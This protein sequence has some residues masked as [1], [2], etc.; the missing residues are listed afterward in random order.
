MMLSHSG[1]GS[2]AAKMAFSTKMEKANLVGL[3]IFKHYAFLPATARGRFRLQIPSDAGPRKEMAV[4]TQKHFAILFW[5]RSA[6][7]QNPFVLNFDPHASNPVY[8]SIAVAVVSQHAICEQIKVT[9][10]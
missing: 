1:N 3:L 9:R 8:I 4:R 6:V 5:F 10:R 7:S 2:A